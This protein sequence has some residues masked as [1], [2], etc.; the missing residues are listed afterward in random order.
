MSREIRWKT[1][2]LVICTHCILTWTD[3]WFLIW[4]R[5]W[6]TSA[7]P[8]GGTLMPRLQLHRRVQPRRQRA[9]KCGTSK[10]R[11]LAPHCSHPSWPSFLTRKPRSGY[12]DCSQTWHGPCAQ[13]TRR[14]IAGTADLWESKCIYNSGVVR[15]GKKGAAALLKIPGKFKT[16]LRF[17]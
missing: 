5:R 14:Q 6:N 11:T 9:R 13:T 17:L 1:I 10:K 12:G 15:E 8:R 2:I 3:V 7:V 4:Y 16:L